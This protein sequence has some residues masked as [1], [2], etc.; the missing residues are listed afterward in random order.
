[1]GQAD[2]FARSSSREQR[3]GELF[4]IIAVLDYPAEYQR[5]PRALDYLAHIGQSGP[6]AG[7]YLILEWNGAPSAAEMARFQNAEIID[8]AGAPAECEFDPVAPPEMREKLLA[9][10]SKMK[11]RSTGGDWNSLVRPERFFSQSGEK[12][13]GTP[14]GERLNMWFGESQ[15]QKPCAHGMLAGQTGSGKSFLLH[16]FMSTGLAARYSPE[17]LQLVLVDGKQG[18]EFESY[19]T[20]PHA[21]VVCLRTAPAVAR[22][23]LEDF[24]AEMEDRWE[25]FQLNGVQKLED[26]RR[27]TGQK[28]PRMVMV[29]DE[30]QQLLEGDADRGSQLLSKVL[31]KGRAAGTH[32]LLGSQTFEVRGLPVSAMTHVHLRVTLSLP[33]DTISAMNAF[34]AE[35][36]KLIRELAPRGQVVINDEGGRDGANHRGAVARL[37]DASGPALPQIIA[38]ITARPRGGRELRWF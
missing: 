7:R 16:V 20:L 33:G 2:N 25:K 1:M 12:M 18:V 22:S 29:V 37:E 30:Y 27:K 11:S 36:K 14:V 9:A 34:S 23:V 31:E 19:R 8:V 13:V 26:Y 6:R 15:E 32:L 35:G 3:A 5:D 17:E 10:V 24:A 21:K 38:E 28:M 4:E